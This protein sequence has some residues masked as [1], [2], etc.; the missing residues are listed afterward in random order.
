MPLPPET[1]LAR[2]KAKALRLLAARPRTEAQ[3]RE[4]LARDGL[5]AEAEEVLA[6][7]RRLGYLDDEAYARA[8]ARS[9]TAPGRLG[10]QLAERRLMAA[11]VPP[12]VARD[13]VAAALLG[14]EPGAEAAEAELCRALASRRAGGAPLESLDEGAR[15]RMARFLLGRGFSGRAVALVLGVCVDSE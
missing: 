4:R 12:G 8:R 3:V 7:L 1:P 13:A 11:G 6:W 2:A 5:A 14:A 9:L 15:A 10:P